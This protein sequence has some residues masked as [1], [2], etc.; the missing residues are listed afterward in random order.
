M[1]SGDD[2]SSGFANMYHT[3]GDEFDR[4]FHNAAIEVFQRW[5]LTTPSTEKENLMKV[6]V[7]NH[8]KGIF[9]EKQYFSCL[10]NMW[11]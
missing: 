1:T 10:H 7:M 4:E 9:L 3:N 11:V 5:D 6:A 2:F 8:I